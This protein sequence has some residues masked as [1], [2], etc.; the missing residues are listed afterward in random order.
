MFIVLLEVIIMPATFSPLRYPG[1]KSQLFSY[2]K[3]FIEFNSFQDYTYV[4]PF[5]GGAG[6]ALKL[7]YRNI[8]PKI[9]INDYDPA[10]YAVWHSC[11]N[12][13][14]EFCKLI[15][16][17]PLNVEEWIKQKE[18]YLAPEE[19]SMLKLGFATLYLNRT[20]RSGIVTGGVLG[21]KDQNGKYKMDVRFNRQTLSRKVMDIFKHRDQIT[22]TNY[23]A[24][25]ILSKDY[26]LGE[27]CFLNI[28]PPYV[29]KGEQLYR[30]FFSENDHRELAR[31]IKC[32][33]YP[34][35]VTYDICDL[36]A[37]IYQE[38]RHSELDVRYSA[39]VKRN[40]H[41]YIFFS[42]NTSIPDSIQIL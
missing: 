22:L 15:R 39:N 26:D 33:N 10:I 20:N 16:T 37:E 24:K 9:V 6:L 31:F 27:K 19:N 3:E 35:V 41:E 23:D 40:A 32:C 4:E 36:V 8:V 5:A 42:N 2:M 21:G 17:T 1:G 18:I 30:N 34:W 12:A 25:Y 14:E 11:L 28:D 38:F 13:P 7:L 29:K